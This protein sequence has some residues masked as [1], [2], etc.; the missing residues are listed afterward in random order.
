MSTV[1]NSA[2]AIVINEQDQVLLFKFDFSY[3]TDGGIMWITPGGALE[4]GESYEEAL[5]RE[6]EEETG[7]RISGD[8]PHIRTLE[9]T[10]NTGTNREFISHEQYYLVRVNNTDISTQ[11]FTDN[12]R[13]TF[14][15]ARWWSLAEIL[16]SKENF[17][18]T[19]L[20]LMALKCISLDQDLSRA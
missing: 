16:D 6:M 4:K 15:D 8:L 11:N 2:R 19:D 14:K 5:R 12:E 20:G 18:P 17:G 1:R 3:L 13:K 9:K 7:I 10:F